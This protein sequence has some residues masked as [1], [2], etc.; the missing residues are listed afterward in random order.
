MQVLCKL[1]F[2]HIIGVY[3]P[4]YSAVRPMKRLESDVMWYNTPIFPL[5][6]L[7]YKIE[8]SLYAEVLQCLS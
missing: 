2:L 8:P 6:Y 1:Q 4:L 5:P 7:P 3:D